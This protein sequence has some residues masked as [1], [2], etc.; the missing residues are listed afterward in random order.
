M[1]MYHFDSDSDSAPTSA[2]ANSIANVNLSV[3]GDST[4]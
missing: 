4:S 3:A 2:T 1:P